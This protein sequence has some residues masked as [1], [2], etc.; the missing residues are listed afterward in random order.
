M[1]DAAGEGDGLAAL[2][3]LEP[4]RDD[5]SDELVPIHP[6]GELGLDVIASL[7][8]DAAKIRIDRRIDPRPHQVALLDQVRHLRTLD[9]GLEDAAET[10]TIATA[11]CCG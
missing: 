7:R 5:V 3:V 6:L 8:F 9:H 1:T 10:A 4:M 2:A 11:W